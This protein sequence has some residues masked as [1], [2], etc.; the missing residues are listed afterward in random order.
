MKE[1]WKGKLKAGMFYSQISFLLE[2]IFEGNIK[3]NL[4]DIYECRNLLLVM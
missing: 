4:K 1:I 3:G 2:G